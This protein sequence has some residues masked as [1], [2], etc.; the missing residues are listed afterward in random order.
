MSP[1]TAKE[2]WI[3][4]ADDTI[5]FVVKLSAPEVPAEVDPEACDPDVDPAAEDPALEVLD[6]IGREAKIWLQTF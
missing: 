2:S 1:I 6:E 4:T 5:D 3:A